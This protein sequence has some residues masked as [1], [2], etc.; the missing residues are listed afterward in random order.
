MKDTAESLEIYKYL[1]DLTLLCVEDDK[2]TQLLYNSIFQDFVKEIV[3]TSNGQLG[4]ESFK[5]INQDIDIIVSDY[6]MPIMNGLE[7]IKDIRQ[8]DKLIPI[9]FASALEDVNIIVEALSL[10]VNYFIQKP[11]QSEKILNALENCAKLLIANKTLKKQKEKSLYHSYQEDMGF[12]KELNI[13]RNDFYYQMIE[14]DTVALVDFLYQPLDVLSGD[15]YCARCIAPLNSFYLMVD[16][17]G[18]G[19]SA[20]L[21][22]MIMTS[23]VNHMID[24]MIETDSFD[25]AVLIHET[26]EYVKPILLD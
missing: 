21:T 18:K 19:L 11:I 13:L 12:A 1:Q 24:K 20:S 17:M 6:S 2:T 10:E 9:I 8:T 25:F 16:G 5:N 23:F 4:L 14:G 7:M 15:A 26:M 22:A 3:F